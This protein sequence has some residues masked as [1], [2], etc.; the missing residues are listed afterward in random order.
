M[1]IVL[2]ALFLRGQYVSDTLRGI[3]IPELEN[4]TGQKVTASRFSINI[5]PLFL[6]AKDMKVSD[7]SGQTILDTRRVK[8]YI[9][10]SGIFNRQITLQRLVIEDTSVTTHREQ[11]D[12]IIS[13]VKAYLEKERELAFKVKI[14]VVEVVRGNVFLKDE[15]LKG[16]L[17]IKGLSGEYLTGESQKLN[18]AVKE[19]GIEKEGWPEIVCDL[20][21]AVVLRKDCN[22]S[23]TTG[24]RR[25]RIKICRTRI[26]WP[27]ER[28]I[29]SRYR[30]DR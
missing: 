9:T 24:D 27:W 21:T 16:E 7:A 22:G 3:I 17:V 23:E 2:F 13:H 6:E 8:G 29:N 20:N 25:I 10:L 30:P 15:N 5:L 12:G 19:L 26:L 4:M 11:L 18:A 14:R 1:A 28:H